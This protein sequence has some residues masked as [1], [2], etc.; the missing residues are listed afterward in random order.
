[1]KNMED[2]VDSNISRVVSL[3]WDTI[4]TASWGVIGVM[5]AFVVWLLRIIGGIQFSNWKKGRDEINKK[6]QLLEESVVGLEE[7]VYFTDPIE[8][9]KTN[10][11]RYA[12]HQFMAQKNILY[13]I[14]DH[15]DKLNDKIDALGNEDKEL[16]KE[17]KHLLTT[18]KQNETIN[19]I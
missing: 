17:I 9:K 1:M 19:N 14:D 16:L 8:G 11:R 10:L 3:G 6:I 18:K 15:V 13:M 4:A 2:T 7:V 5:G 12:V